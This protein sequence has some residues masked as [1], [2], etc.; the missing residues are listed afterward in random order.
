M[1]LAHLLSE[2]YVAA[3]GGQSGLYEHKLDEFSEP[4]LI[5]DYHLY[6]SFDSFWYTICVGS[7][8]D[9]AVKP[10]SHDRGYWASAVGHTGHQLGR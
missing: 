5:N 6:R 8:V 1:Q 3:H 10:R 4:Y 9:L 7:G 2:Y